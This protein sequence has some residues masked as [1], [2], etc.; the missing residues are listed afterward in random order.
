MNYTHVM[1]DY[2]SYILCNTVNYNRVLFCMSED[3]SIARQVNN[4]RI[5]RFPKN[6]QIGFII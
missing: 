6:E 3:Y 1:C 5:Q 4:G 2:R